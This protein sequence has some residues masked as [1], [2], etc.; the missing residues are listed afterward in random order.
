MPSLSAHICKGGRRM[1][2]LLH[3]GLR[4]RWQPR[5]RLARLRNARGSRVILAGWA[6]AA[7]TFVD[8]ERCLMWQPRR[9]R[10]DPCAVHF[11]FCGTK[12]LHFQLSQA[13]QGGA[14]ERRQDARN[15][16]GSGQLSRIVSAMPGVWT[17]LA[18]VWDSLRASSPLSEWE[19]AHSDIAQFRP[20][21]TE[22]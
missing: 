16:A 9:N 4:D 7:H 6:A 17:Q 10:G 19:C 21:V 1:S 2:L 12:S 3:R 11:R 8:P 14:R 5:E 18:P 22:V 20:R 15:Q 13:Q